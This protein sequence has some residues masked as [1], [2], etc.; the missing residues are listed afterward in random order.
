MQL[1]PILVILHTVLITDLIL[2]LAGF[3]VL[4]YAM[5][6]AVEGYEDEFGFHELRAVVVSQD[7]RLS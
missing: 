4:W 2:T 6:Y 7:F 1:S 3:G 5:K